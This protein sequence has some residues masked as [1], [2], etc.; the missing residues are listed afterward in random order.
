MNPGI[1]YGGVMIN[2]TTTMNPGVYIMAG[3]DFATHNGGNNITGSGVTIYMTLDPARPGSYGGM[4]W[5]NG[6]LTMDLTAPT[7]G[8]FQGILLF[9]DRNSTVLSMPLQ[10]GN[11]SSINLNGAIYFPRAGIDAH[12]GGNLNIA[13]NVIV[14][15]L[16]MNGNTNFNI[17]APGTIPIFASPSGVAY[18]PMAWQ[19]F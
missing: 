8:P 14:Q 15:S 5:G 18:S 12:G 1:Y 13:G 7:S 9:Q 2:G 10:A 16:S 19:D 4:N 3:G 6:N 11:S 17:T